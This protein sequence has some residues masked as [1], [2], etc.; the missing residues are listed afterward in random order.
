MAKISNE[1]KLEAVKEW[2]TKNGIKYVENHMTTAKLNI[3]L[4]IPSL[5]IAIHV[6]DDD[7]KFYKKTRKWCKPFFIRES[8]TKKFVLEKLQNCCY[9]AMVAMQKKFEKENKK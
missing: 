3:D 7:G 2:L 9:D 6:G 5:F 1:S 4:W 8:E